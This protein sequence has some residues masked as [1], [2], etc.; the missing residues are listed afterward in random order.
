[1]DVAHLF[2]V[3]GDAVALG[4]STL[5]DG[6]TRVLWAVGGSALANPSA[7]NTK[8]GQAILAADYRVDELFLR[9]GLV[10]GV[11]WPK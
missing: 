6:A 11:V 10:A 5:A 4:S 9:S 2:A 1:M 7:T 3:R 8:P